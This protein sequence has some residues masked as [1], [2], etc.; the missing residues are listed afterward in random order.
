MYCIETTQSGVLTIYTSVSTDTYGHLYN[1][2]DSDVFSDNDSGEGRNFRIV[3]PVRIGAHTVELRHY[4]T[5]R[6][7]RL[8]FLF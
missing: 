5:N 3:Y 2:G 7:G 6:H 1:E 4:S 8:C